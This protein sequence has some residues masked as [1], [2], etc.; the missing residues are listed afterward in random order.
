MRSASLRWKII[1]ALVICE[2]GLIPVYLATH[3]A[4]QVMHL[5]LR[6]RVQPFKASGEWEEVNFQE[7]I[8][9]NE[10][11]IIICD[12]WD[13][14]WCTGA[15]KRTD[16]LAQ[17]MAPVIDVARAHGIVIIHAPS[18]TMEYYM[19]YPQR[20]RMLQIAKVNPPPALAIAR[21]PLPIDAADGGCD[22][23]PP[24]KFF[25]AWKHENS[26]ITIHDA[27]FISENGNE[28]YSLLRQR[29]IKNLMVMGVH[30]N[31]C[32]LTRTF[33]IRRMTEWGIRC[34]L[35]RDLTDS[36]YNPKDRP[37]V[38]HDQGTEL[39]IEYIEQN[40]CPTV[41]SSDLVSALGKAG[42]L[43]QK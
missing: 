9:T 42:T 37:Y 25:V 41:L 33:A 11:A 1:L 32:V 14:H 30:T 16:I 7:D 29:G 5:N 10:A 17:E 27:D 34:I 31:L 2:L 26:A 20:K 24:D 43:G 12:M 21:A 19:D 3:A 23:T 38:R 13:N 15:A 18:E 28:V 6:T 22:T 8:P 39:V 36:L 40:L 4:G 35:V